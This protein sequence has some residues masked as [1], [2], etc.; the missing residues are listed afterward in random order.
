MGTSFKRSHAWTAAFSVPDPAAGHC[1][2]T[3]SPETTGHSLASLGQSLVGS[4][5]LGPG[6]N[7]FLFV[8]SKSLFPQSCVWQFIV[9]LIA[10]SSKRVYA[11]SR[12]AAPRAPAVLVHHSFSSRNKCLLISWLQS[13]SA[14]ILGPPKIKSVTV[15]IVSPTICHEVMGSD[16]MIL[17]F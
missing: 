11:I 8:P 13:Q 15:F 1:Q 14:V 12:S 2:P 10:T 7:K 5:L 6:M 17:V 16:A 9:E 3:P 4:L